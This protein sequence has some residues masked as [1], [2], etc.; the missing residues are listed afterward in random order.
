LESRN[1]S[2]EEQAEWLRRHGMHSEH[3]ALW[4]QELIRIIN[5]KQ[6]DLKA[7]N[8]E[9]KKA[10]KQLQKENKRKTAM[11]FQF[12]D[13][14]RNRWSIGK[15]AKIFG[16]SSSGYY[17]WKGRKPSHRILEDAALLD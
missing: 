11:I 7:E 13:T 14:N 6:T 15:M 8:A 10:N 9:L 3:L 4:E 16:V 12:M 17:A 2:E 5:D 1:I